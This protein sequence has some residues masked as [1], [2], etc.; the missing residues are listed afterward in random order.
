MGW[1]GLT[2]TGDPALQ[3][4]EAQVLQE[5]GCVPLLLTAQDV[6]HYYE[7]FSNGVLWP[8]FHALTDRLPM[9]GLH[10]DTYVRVNERMAQLV[11]VP[12]MQARFNIVEEFPLSERGS[13]GF[14]STGKH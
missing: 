12:V 9:D 13:G 1:S 3:A 4:Q 11:I 5:H 6:E 2:N 14:G 7:A 10:Y 8:A